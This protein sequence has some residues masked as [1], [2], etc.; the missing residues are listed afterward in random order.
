MNTTTQTQSPQEQAVTQSPTLTAKQEMV[1]KLK[2]SIDNNGRYAYRLNDM[3]AGYAAGKGV[4]NAEARKEI[5][6]SFAKQVG[7]SP[8]AYLEQHFETRKSHDSS[9]SR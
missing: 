4:S 6:A 2:Q 5:E 8:K 7:K 3:S 1:F 9:K